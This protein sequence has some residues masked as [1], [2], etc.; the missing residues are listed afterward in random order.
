[1][2]SYPYLVIYAPSGNQ[3]NTAL[4]LRS[5]WFIDRRLV[6]GGGRAAVFASFFGHVWYPD[7]FWNPQ[8]FLSRYAFRPHVSGE[9]A[10]ESRTFEYALQSGYF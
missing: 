2:Q 6:G 7:I 9:F 1:M 4:G 10:G 8:L 5:N 3:P